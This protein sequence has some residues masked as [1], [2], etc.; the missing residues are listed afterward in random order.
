MNK[1]GY[2]A[3]GAA[4]A[5]LLFVSACGQSAP[6]QTPDEIRSHAAE[7]AKAEAEA[8]MDATYRREHPDNGENKRDDKR[9]D[10]RDPEPK[11]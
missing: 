5:V 3:A 4:V 8:R 1:L 10:K 9:D 7:G 6:A 2:A 11:R